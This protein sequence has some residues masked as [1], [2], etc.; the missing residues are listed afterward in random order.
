[1]LPFRQS[2]IFSN[3]GPFMDNVFL[4]KVFFRFHERRRPESQHKYRTIFSAWN[5][6]N[7][8]FFYFTILLYTSMVLLN[9]YKHTLKVEEL[10]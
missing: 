2:L 1:M 9:M 3:K 4:W 7:I 8:K 6:K 10:I 5:S